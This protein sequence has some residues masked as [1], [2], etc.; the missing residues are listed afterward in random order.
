MMR[1]VVT[2]QQ[3]QIVRS[4]AERAPA[5][6]VEVIAV[7]RPLLD[8]EEP[9]S[10]AAALARARP[11]VIV[12]AAA[13]TAVDLAEQDAGR[14]FAINA[15]GAGAV[16]RAAAAL[17]VPVIHLSTDYVF[18]GKKGKPYLE[19]DAT[20]PLSVYG[21]SKLEGE[22]QVAQAGANHVILRAAWVYSPF[23]SNFVRTMLR[24]AQSRDE[25]SVVADQFSRP[26]SALDI[27]DAVLAIARRL[28]AD[29][30]PSIRGRFHLS[31]EGEASWADFASAIFAILSERT[32]R[33]VRVRPI[34]T[35]DYPTPARRPADSRL[36]TGKLKTHHGIILP[37]W[38]S[39]TRIVVD[40]LLAEGTAP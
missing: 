19:T 27:A 38:R 25:I 39:S 30:D 35:S 17:E 4:I 29:P 31:A 2:G 3:G 22:R 36:D 34:P 1:I 7:G 33:T 15:A 9:D 40:R 14:A 8:L 23:G 28:A 21:A 20:G 32:G 6:N 5:S 16:A 37:D 26:T 12:S 10:V 11:D 18:D 13:Y 24:L